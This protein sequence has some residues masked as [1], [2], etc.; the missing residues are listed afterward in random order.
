MGRL[1][2]ALA[3]L[4]LCGPATTD[5]DAARARCARTVQDAPP[6]WQEDLRLLEELLAAPRP[7]DLLWQSRVFLRASRL[8]HAPT[9]R[10]LPA[11]QWLARDGS[12]RSRANLVLYERRQGLP[13]EPPQPDEGPET[14]LERC[15]ALWAEARLPESRAALEKA[16]QRFPDDSRFRDNLLWLDLRPPQA[17]RFDATPRQLALAVLT[18]RASRTQAASKR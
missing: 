9:E 3:A 15:L 12:D 18:A 13:L 14:T 10:V 1:S 8:E 4:A 5:A 2:Y 17:L 6:A 7:A 11:W 16:V